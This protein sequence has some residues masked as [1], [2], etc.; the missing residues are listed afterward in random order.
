M[1]LLTLRLKGWHPRWRGQVAAGEPFDCKNHR[2]S[3]RRMHRRLIGKDSN[4]G[5]SGNL[6]AECGIKVMQ[7]DYSVDGSACRGPPREPARKLCESDADA[8]DGIDVPAAA[9]NS[10]NAGTPAGHAFWPAWSAPLVY[11]VRH[12]FIFLAEVH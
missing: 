7:Y 1:A 2:F 4:V 6:M 5:P 8:A 3:T 11:V 10:L 9:V 12:W